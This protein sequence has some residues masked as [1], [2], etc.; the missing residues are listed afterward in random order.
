MYR[1]LRK[2]PGIVLFRLRDERPANRV[3]TAASLL[4]QY[5]DRLTGNFTVAAEESVRIRPLRRST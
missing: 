3:R 2:A 4:E 5:A 1:S